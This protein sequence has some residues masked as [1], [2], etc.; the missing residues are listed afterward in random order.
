MYTYAGLCKRVKVEG[1]VEIGSNSGHKRF[2][3]KDMST[4]ASWEGSRLGKSDSLFESVHDSRHFQRN[5]FP[6]KLNS[7]SFS[8][9]LDK[10]NKIHTLATAESKAGWKVPDLTE[11]R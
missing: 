1:R 8:W 10:G 4:S 5:L 11:N 7:M 2:K 3:G 9:S 6:L